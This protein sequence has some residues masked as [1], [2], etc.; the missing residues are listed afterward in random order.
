[1]VEILRTMTRTASATNRE[2]QTYPSRLIIFAVLSPGWADI[3]VVLFSLAIILLLPEKQTT[4]VHRC[5][6]PF[7]YVL[8]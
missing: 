6:R 8:N 7:S 1:M 4:V 3:D 5:G 2:H